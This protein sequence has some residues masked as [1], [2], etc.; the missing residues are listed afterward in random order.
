MRASIAA[1]SLLLAACTAPPPQPLGPLVLSGALQGSIVDNIYHDRRGWF[2][3]ATP[4]PVGGD[5]YRYMEVQEV[6]PQDISFVNFVPQTAPGEYYRA[7]AEDF[8]ASNHPVPSFDTIADNALKV[9]GKQVMDARLEPMVLQQEKT[10]S[11]GATQGLI[12][13]YTQKVSTALLA[14]DLMNGLA[15]AEDYTA[16]ILIYV[17]AK[18]GKVAMLWAEWPEDCSVCQPVPGTPAKAGADAIDR[19]LASDPRAAV[20]LGSFGYAAGASA[21]Q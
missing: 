10:W 20:F 21:Y 4:F 19:A 13:L 9:Y 7:Y 5:G 18:N 3:V 8:F 15:L 16:Y 11:T 2:T 12:R 17:T 14:H 6:Y 1:L